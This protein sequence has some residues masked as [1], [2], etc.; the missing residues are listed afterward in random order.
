MIK[1]KFD[2]KTLRNQKTILWGIKNTN[3]QEVQGFPKYD[4]NQI[5]RDLEKN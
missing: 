5:Y 4:L 3:F 2:N 1:Q